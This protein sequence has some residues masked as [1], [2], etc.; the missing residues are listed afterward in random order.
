METNHITVTDLVRRFS[1]I[2]NRVYYQRQT[3]L[4]TRGNAVVAQLSPA[5]ETRTGAELAQHWRERPRLTADDAARWDAE[6]AALKASIP[7]LESD[8]WAT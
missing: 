2:V 8:P 5:T 1:D 3:F 6:L 4:L 7:P